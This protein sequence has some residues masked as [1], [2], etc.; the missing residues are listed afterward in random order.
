[1]LRVCGWI[2]GYR[3]MLFEKEVLDLGRGVGMVM[4]LFLVI[5]SYKEISMESREIVGWNKMGVLL[6]EDDK[7]REG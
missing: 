6:G 4:Y 2:F 1:M 7:V 3:E 5:V